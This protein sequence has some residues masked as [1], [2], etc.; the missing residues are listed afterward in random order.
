MYLYPSHSALLGATS[1]RPSSHK[2]SLANAVSASTFSD[3]RRFS[4][5]KNFD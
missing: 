5:S 2:H 3:V 1:T 4:A